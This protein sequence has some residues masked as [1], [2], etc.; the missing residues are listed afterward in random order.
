[1][2]DCMNR[3]QMGLASASTSAAVPA[4]TRR[5]PVAALIA[6][7]IVAAALLFAMPSLA[8][9]SNEASG[10][11]QG[12]ES[13]EI[14]LSRSDSSTSVNKTPDEPKAPPAYTAQDAYKSTPQST[15][16][17]VD[18]VNGAGDSSD[19]S[20]TPGD[21]KSSINDKD[22]DSDS[23]SASN[24][25]TNGTEDTD[26][27]TSNEEQDPSDPKDNDDS[28]DKNNGAI[29][30][31]TDEIATDKNQSAHPTGDDSKADDVIATPGDKGSA[32]LTAGATSVKTE[33]VKQQTN[34]ST[35][36][37]ITTQASA[38]I[39]F[40][41]AHGWTPEVSDAMTKTTQATDIWSNWAG[42]KTWGCPTDPVFTSTGKRLSY[43]LADTP[44]LSLADA[45]ALG[46]NEVVNI[47]GN[48]KKNWLFVIHQDNGSKAVWK[49]VVGTLATINDRSFQQGWYTSITAY[50]IMTPSEVTVSMFQNKVETKNQTT[51]MADVV[52]PPSPSDSSKKYVWYVNVNSGVTADMIAKKQYFKA[53][54]FAADTS[55]TGVTISDL[56]NKLWNFRS[57]TGDASAYSHIYPVVEGFY[58]IEVEE[59]DENAI[60]VIYNG[61]KPAAATGTVSCVPANGS[62]SKDGNT[63]F[64]VSSDIPTLAGYKFN[65]W[66]TQANGGGTAYAAGATIPG[67]LIKGDITL[68]A[69]WIQQ[70]SITFNANGT[71]VTGLPSTI[72]VDYNAA[73][74][75]PSSA[76]T[77]TNF[78][79]KGWNTAANGSGTSYTAG[80]SIAH[81]TTNLPLYAQWEAYPVVTY[82]AN[83][84]TGAPSAD[85][86]AP[87]VYNIKTGTPTR[88]GYVFGGWTPTQN[89]TANG[90]YS[91][92]AT[93]SGSQRSMNVTSNVTLWALWNPVVTYSAGT[94]PAGAKDTI[95]NMPSTTTYT[96]DYNGTHT[97]LTTPIPTVTGY[98]FGGWAK[99]TAATTKVTSLTNVTA[100]VTL[101]PIWTEKSGYTVQF[102]DQATATTDGAAYNTQNNLKWTG[103][104][105]V[106]TAP[107][108][109]GYTFGGW[110][111]QKDNQGS[112]TG[113]V[114]AS[115][116]GVIAT[117][118][119]TF[120]GIWA[121]E[122]AGNRADTLKIYAKWTE[123][124]KVSV[125]LNP[126]GGSYGTAGTGVT[127]IGNILNG[128]TYTIPTNVDNPTR[129]GYNFKE[130]NTNSS[131]T[132]TAYHAGN[133]TPALT[134]NLTLYAVWTGAPVTFTFEPG[135]TTGIT[136]KKGSASNPYTATAN[137]GAKL[138]ADAGD[139]VYTRTG[140]TFKNWSY[141]NATGGTGTVATATASAQV[142][143]SNFTISWSGNSFDGTLKGTATLTAM[144]DPFTF[145][146]QWNADGGTPT[147]TTSGHKSTD[148]VSIPTATSAIPTR[149]G[150][151]FQ[152]WR[153]GQ[154][155]AGVEVN[156]SK[157]IE[158]TWTLAGLA[159]NATLTAYAQWKENIV[160]LTFVGHKDKNNAI[161]ANVAYNDNNGAVPTTIYVGAATGAIYSSSTATTPT[162]F[163]IS[164]KVKPSIVNT[165]FD[166]LKWQKNGTDLA[167]ANYTSAGVL[168]VPTNAQGLY[169]TAT[170]NLIMGPKQ[171]GYTVEYYLQDV[172]G[173]GY[174]KDATL[175]VTSGTAPFGYRVESGTSASVNDTSSLV[176]FV[177]KTLTGFTYNA[178]VTG[179]NGFIVSIGSN[180][181]ANL[182]KLYYSRN[183]ANLNISYAGAVPPGVTYT[184]A[185]QSVRYDTQV[186]LTTPTAPTGYKFTGWT[187][188]SGSL[189]SGEN[190]NIPTGGNASFHMPDNA[191]TIRGN[192][193]KERYT[194]VFKLSNA[195]DGSVVGN[196]SGTSTFTVSYGDT[197]ATAPTAAPNDSKK[198]YFIG[199]NV[200]TGCTG[201][202]ENTGTLVGTKQNSEING[203]F[204]INSN[205]VFVGRFGELIAVSYLPGANGAF[206]EVNGNMAGGTVTN[207]GTVYENLQQTWTL[208]GFAHGNGY[209]NTSS[210]ENPN[211]G[212]NTGNPAANPGWKF[213]GWSWVDGA[214]VARQNTG[215]Y[216]NYVFVKDSGNDMPTL[217]DTSYKFTALWEKTWQ[218]VHFSDQCANIAG[219]TGTGATDL[220]QQVGDRVTLPMTYHDVDNKGAYTFLGWTTVGT[221]YV[222][223]TSPLYTN[224]A[225]HAFTMTA[226]T[227]NDAIYKDFAEVIA[228]GHYGVTLYPVFQENKATINYTF[229]TGCGSMGT[230]TPGSESINMASGTAAGATATA[231]TGHVFRG[232]FKDAAGTQAVDSS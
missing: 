11:S 162:A 206:T 62:G 197:I 226:G 165:N 7:V 113:T 47:F 227:Q 224:A 155:G 111:L 222:A 178:G 191:L 79:F 220:K 173:S 102:F 99:S 163:N 37:N 141:T 72:T 120:N 205:T 18:V 183:S 5:G 87:G 192:W 230:V 124:T 189:Q 128:A 116:A 4:A 41:F 170:Y 25:G 57:G 158:N 201:S 32:D 135:A 66:N 133:T 218:Q 39:V 123:K 22:S 223:G 28:T 194:A 177:R 161:T 119:G 10:G 195:A 106:P 44:S 88:T 19:K 198:Y 140:Y 13:Q 199:W 174:T 190:L 94:A 59:A 202:N 144:W 151:T 154:N 137:Y 231:A 164:R 49:R 148:Q 207:A 42:K 36:S 167:A 15:G 160:E 103:A 213:V 20:Y 105:T 95:T 136:Y 217:C 74:A 61:N 71:G 129:P 118:M 85:T 58:I 157:T 181:S 53:S 122:A 9:A 121:A 48:T 52:V 51:Y 14:L 215:H 169:E 96:V 126:N 91:Y 110:Y 16:S 100:P 46:L 65:G 80:Q 153:T 188:T 2:Q 208:P 196:M 83:S 50:P 176:T 73:T 81:L 69:Q 27:S 132:G 229:A 109:V 187:V 221:G 145:K 179:T 117:G 6:A 24:S 1:M 84:G 97:V 175:T 38:N 182:I 108:K 203:T 200:Y 17:G 3:E 147:T 30:D 93:I 114:F 184:P 209:T 101:I 166:F 185:T 112:G 232:W 228:D 210:F 64:T 149:P 143:V 107:T 33:E 12:T 152:G 70:L 156:N 55:G 90:L 43:T 29:S 67:S 134:S 35:Q 211:T 168:T 127:T 212:R 104:V 214:G 146:I 204:P 159:N 8:Y 34:V 45:T 60:T 75:I 23:D 92:N 98:T 138:T 130:W 193:E 139:T 86:V 180:P 172:T 68:Y 150:Y 78:T 219:V 63:P 171:Y 76:P 31:S 142:D 21:D 115:A 77:R 216:V 54:E 89:S 56:L 225:G 40:D 125:T 131:G 186:T 82:N 26:D